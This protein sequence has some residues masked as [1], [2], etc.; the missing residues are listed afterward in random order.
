MFV[1]LLCNQ[2]A[3]TS[4]FSLFLLL[5]LLEETRAQCRQLQLEAERRQLEAQDGWAAAAQLKQHLRDFF[6]QLKDSIEGTDSDV[7][8][9]DEPSELSLAIRSNLQS[10][11]NEYRELEET[12]TKNKELITQL[13]GNF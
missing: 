7:E 3:K 9:L 13:T 2:I 11:K 12:N 6:L 5:E 4:T 10:L 8:D 1:L